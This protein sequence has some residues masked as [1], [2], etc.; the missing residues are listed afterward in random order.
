MRAPDFDGVGGSAWTLVHNEREEWAITAVYSALV[1]APHSHPWWP[2]HLLCVISLCDI[3]G[4]K[5]AVKK[6]PEAE[7]EISVLS[8][9][10][11]TYPLDPDKPP[12]KLLMPPDVV[13]QFHGIN[14]AKANRLGELAARACAD[15][16]LNPDVDGR[17]G[18][19]VAIAETVDHLKGL[20]P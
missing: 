17:A 11:E 14:A 15:G 6:Y 3:P 5:P 20:H 19:K 8:I 16:A 2:W 18:W 1:F 12:F 7:Y 10:P 4:M 13:I 9:D